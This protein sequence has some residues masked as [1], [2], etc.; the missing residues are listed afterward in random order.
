MDVDNTSNNNENMETYMYRF[1]LCK[2][3][4]EYITHVSVY[5]Q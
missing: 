5:L 4:A 2:V 3:F 1:N